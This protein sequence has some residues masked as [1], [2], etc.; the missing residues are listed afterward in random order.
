MFGVNY[1][2]LSR[3]LASKYSLASND[4]Q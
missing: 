1:Q 4:A 3:R 2:Q